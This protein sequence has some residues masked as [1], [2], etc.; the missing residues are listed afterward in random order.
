VAAFLLWRELPERETEVLGLAVEPCSR[1]KG[2]AR[3]LL[4][5]LLRNRPGECFLEVRASNL[6]A[7]RLYSKLGFV[8]CGLRRAYYH[9]P[10]EDALVMRRPEIPPKD[11]TQTH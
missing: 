4:G 9:H 8:R 10:V 2:L 1:R 11:A 7:Q 5:E 6:P 3:A